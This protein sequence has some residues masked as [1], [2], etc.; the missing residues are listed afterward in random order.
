MFAEVS[1][2]Q[3]KEKFKKRM[4]TPVARNPGKSLKTKLRRLK[5]VEA[6]A[7]KLKKSLQD[8]QTEIKNSNR[9]KVKDATAALDDGAKVRD[10]KSHLDEIMNPK[11]F[12]LFTV[13]EIQKQ[14]RDNFTFVQ[15]GWIFIAV[16]FTLASIIGMKM[17]SHLRFMDEPP[18]NNPNM[19]PQVKSLTCLGSCF[20][21]IGACSWFIVLF[22]GMFG[23]LLQPLSADLDH[24][25]CLHSS[26][27]LPGQLG[28]ITGNSRSKTFQIHAGQRWQPLPV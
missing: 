7:N 5:S 19:P 24:V 27:C 28:E 10:M 14:N 23:A 26:P 20:A 3:V 11:K 1:N 18:A 9:R 6:S 25:R 21:R 12:S 8:I 2:W 15:F 17:C 4:P 16:I 13:A 22:F